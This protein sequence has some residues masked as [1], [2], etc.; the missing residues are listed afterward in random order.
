VEIPG[1]VDSRVAWPDRCQI[2]DRIHLQGR[3]VVWE[4]IDLRMDD[5]TES[6][7]PVSRS[8]HLI[9]HMSEVLRRDEHL[10]NNSAS[11]CNAL[12]DIGT[13]TARVNTRGHVEYNLRT[14]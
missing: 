14:G 12:Q 13:H 10:E 5:A 2:E 3:N 6:R 4:C 9:R 1:I 7:L 8:W 11:I